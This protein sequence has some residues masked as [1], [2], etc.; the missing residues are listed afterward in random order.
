M[1]LF[2]KLFMMTAVIGF[3]SQSINSKVIAQTPESYLVSGSVKL[4]GQIDHSGIKIICDNIGAGFSTTFYGSIT[5]GSRIYQMSS[6]IT[7]IYSQAVTLS[8]V[9]I[10]NQSNQ[11]IAQSSDPSIL[12]NNYL[13][14]LTSV[15]ISISPG[16]APLESDARLWVTKWYCSFNG[17]TFIVTGKYGAAGTPSS[18]NSISQSASVK[19]AIGDDK[20]MSAGTTL[21]S[22]AQVPLK[23]SSIVSDTIVTNMSGMF[24]K[25]L[26]KG[27]YNFTFIKS[28]YIQQVITKELIYFNKNLTAITL[29]DTP[30][31]MSLSKTSMQLGVVKV[32]QYID[33]VVTI[34]NSGGGILSVGSISSTN[35][36]FT[37]T[38]ITKNMK[39]GENVVDT[40]RFRPTTFGDFSGRMIITSNDPTGPDTI[41]VQ[42]SSPYPTI[43]SSS[44]KLDY[45]DIA[46]NQKGYKTVILTNTSMNH[47]NIDSIYCHSTVFSIDR[48][49]LTIASLDSIIVCYAPIGTGSSTDTL[50]LMNNS[51]STI[52][53][54]ALTGKSP[55]PTISSDK[56]EIIFG[57]RKV[58]S[59]MTLAVAFSNTS[60]NI[61]RA[62]S[63][64]T[65]TPCFVVDTSTLEFS[66]AGNVNVSFKPNLFGNFDDTL[67][68]KNN[69]ATILLKIPLK[70]NSPYPTLSLNKSSLEFSDTPVGSLATLSL[71]MTNT[72]INVLQADSFYTHSSTFRIN[73][74]SCSISA[75]DSINIS[76]LPLSTGGFTDTLFIR[77]NSISGIVKL[78]LA[79][80]SP[81]PIISTMLTKVS[82]QNTALGDSTSSSVVLLNKTINPLSVQSISSAKSTFRF[83]VNLPIT[84]K[85]ND[86]LTVPVWFKPLVLG[87]AIDTLVIMSDGGIL[88]IP[89]TGLSPYPTCHSQIESLDFGAVMSSKVST[90]E[91]VITNGTMNKLFIDSITTT[92]HQFTLNKIVFPY[93]LNTS[94]TLRLS[95]NFVPD[96]VRLFY[97]TLNVYSNIQSGVAKIR[98]LG[99]GEKLTFI[100]HGNA[101]I[102]AQY[103]LSQNFP[104]P[105]N[106]TTNI[107]FGLPLKSIV[108]VKIYDITGRLVAILIDKET[109]AGFYS[110]KFDG[111]NLT[112]GVYLY[113]MTAENGNSVYSET[114][115]FILLK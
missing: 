84:I 71:T 14:P 12:N 88:R 32:N 86:S 46:V 30:P 26:T 1:K 27:V 104:N 38:T 99:K 61:L 6:S 101:E 74:A 92:F 78:P 111:S 5:I 100:D 19:P 55:L 105:F 56:K 53:K 23:E 114:K 57:D 79:G 54:I 17:N 107:S 108:S 15:G 37:G 67:Y 66:T 13:G 83:V 85:A 113:R 106:P 20:I 51:L 36:A 25:L 50:Y 18:I 95:V 35:S 115:R 52:V 82:I 49:K 75:S 42:G 97:D 58:N 112:S 40:I 89:M 39:V 28:G 7:N 103:S 98:L 70:G 73:K 10:Y 72:S 76:F 22:S 33:S 8:K 11:L 91:V 21:I 47:L 2:L 59:T 69:S 102:P 81:K 80:Q 24:N 43:A 4:D 60:I 87:T 64:F 94:D 44:T 110:L 77:N 45:G 96:S 3:L 31:T 68:V 109:T 65:K 16:I 90:K 62:D 63:I 48:N 34:G 93:M 9:E 41:L 29:L